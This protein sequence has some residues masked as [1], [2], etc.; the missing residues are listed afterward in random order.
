MPWDNAT[1]QPD[2]AEKLQQI[3]ANKDSDGKSLSPDT[4]VS[5]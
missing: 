2:P 5:A 3:F 4:S 1:I